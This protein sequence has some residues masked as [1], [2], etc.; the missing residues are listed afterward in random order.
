MKR[1]PDNHIYWIAMFVHRVLGYHT[2]TGR[3]LINASLAASSYYDAFTADRIKAAHD[4]TLED[5]GFADTAAVDAAWL[6]HYTPPYDQHRY[7]AIACG[8]AMRDYKR[9]VRYIAQP[10]ENENYLFA[11]ISMAFKRSQFELIT[12]E[13]VR[14]YRLNPAAIDHP[15]FPTF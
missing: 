12:T 4:Q 3:D 14:T 13:P 11:I 10:T 6:I 9:R 1:L 8:A 7:D 2:F 15:K 5:Y